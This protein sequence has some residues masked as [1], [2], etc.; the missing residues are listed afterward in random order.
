MCLWMYDMM[1]FVVSLN[2]AYVFHDL[3]VNVH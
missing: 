3:F 2:N 1:L